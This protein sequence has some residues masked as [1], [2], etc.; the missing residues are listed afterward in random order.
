MKVSLLSACT[1]LLASA[2]AQLV[3]PSIASINGDRFLSPVSG[4][5]LTGARGLVTAKGPNG[6][7]IRS[8]SPNRDART[9][10]SIYVFGRNSI[11]NVTV[12][13]IITL[14]GR[15]MEFRSNRDY[16]F[17]T[18]IEQPTNITVI[19]SGN[20][21]EAVEIGRRGLNPPKEL[22]TSLDDGDIFGVPNNRS[23]ISQVNPRLEPSR[24][25]LDFWESLSGE[26]V[27]VRRPRVVN[28]PNSFGDTW[29]NYSHVL[30]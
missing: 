4:Q 11:G 10:D 23:L 22:H 7:W 25:G 28:R 21:V 15:V 24:Y 29:V 13:D 6:F 9:S 5:T 16:L 27:T 17:L 20:R 30:R 18:E 1:A 26:L 3:N 8:T 2:S 12:G 19:S 14:N